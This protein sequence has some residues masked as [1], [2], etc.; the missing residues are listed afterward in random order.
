MDEYLTGREAVEMVGRLY[1]LSAQVA[2]QRAAE[3]LERISL[4]ADADRLVRTYSGGMKRRLDLAASLVGRPDVLFLDEPTT[5]IDPRS[6]VDVWALIRDLVSSGTTVL[7]TTQYLDEADRLADR[8][9]VIHEGRLISEGTGNEL[10]D[11]LGG[12]VIQVEVPEAAQAA[13]RAALGADDGTDGTITLPAPAGID[14]TVVIVRRNLLRILRLPQLLVFATVQPVM[15]LIL[16][17][18]VFGG[19]V[20]RA[21]PAAAGGKYI[22][23]LVIDRFRSLPM[24]RSAVL[25][26]RTVA[27]LLRNGFVIGLMIVLGFVL[28]FRPQTS[29][30]SLVGGVLVAMAF[31][32]ALSWGMAS[33]GLAVK[34]SEAAQTASFLPVFPLV[35]A[36]SVFVPTGTLPDWLRVF[37]DHQPVTRTANAVRGLVLGE[38]AL[39]AGQTVAGEVTGALLWAL[40]IIVVFA[41]LAVRLYRRAVS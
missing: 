29:F 27:D 41:P 38:G 30:V 28:G 33:L 1:N 3:V 22:N 25:A 17:N 20:G 36:S 7:L 24:A 21:I 11:R 40:G 39:A 12:A 5:G 9:G 31:A 16:F 15:F 18:Y 23:W 34:N 8:I 6:R 4:A 32:F 2:R 26:G 19:S 13:T 37:A 10:K 35:F 14:P